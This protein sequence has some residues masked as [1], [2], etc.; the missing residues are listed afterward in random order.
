MKCVR[1]RDNFNNQVK[2]DFLLLIWKS[3]EGITNIDYQAC[4]FWQDPNYSIFQAYFL[5][6]MYINFARCDCNTFCEM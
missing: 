6:V 5:I 2:C 3:L 4:L 1:I